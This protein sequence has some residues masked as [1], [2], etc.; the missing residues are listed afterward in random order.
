MD[1]SQNDIKYSW[2]VIIWKSN[3]K[4]LLIKVNKNVNKCTCGR[5]ILHNLSAHGSYIFINCPLLSIMDSF[6]PIRLLII[7]ISLPKGPRMR[8]I[9]AKS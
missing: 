2:K 4:Q 8:F 6:T 1:L 3:H 9:S 7:K 5:S